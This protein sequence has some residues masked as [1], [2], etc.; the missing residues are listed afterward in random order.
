MRKVFIDGKEYTVTQHTV[1]YPSGSAAVRNRIEIHIAEDQM[2]RDEFFALF[3]EPSKLQEIK[4]FET[5]DTKTAEDPAYLKYET[6]CTGY[7]EPLFL[8]VK[9]IDTIEPTEGRTLSETHFVAEL[10]QPLYIERMAA[11]MILYKQHSA[12]I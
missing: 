8:G 9:R 4:I 12:N 1:L 3:S 10:E 5:D 11:Q 7:T 2:T 6:V